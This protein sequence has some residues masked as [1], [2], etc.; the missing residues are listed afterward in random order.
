MFILQ[1]LK[2]LL[3]KVRIYAI[4]QKMST[5]GNFDKRLLLASK[6]AWR[7]GVNAC[8]EIQDK[9]GKVLFCLWSKFNAHIVL[10]LCKRIQELVLEK[11][12]I[13]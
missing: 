10:L 12:R 1:I 8:Y 3:V 2:Y 13:K 9:E 11:S 7:G 6:Y 4:F 5:Y